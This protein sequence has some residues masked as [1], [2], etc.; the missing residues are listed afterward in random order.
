MSSILRS[1]VLDLVNQRISATDLESW[2]VHQLPNIISNPDSIDSDVVSGI[3]LCL[4]ELHSGIRSQEDF[5]AYMRGI[6]DQY[7][8]LREVVFNA[9][10][11][12]NSTASSNTSRPMLPFSPVNTREAVFKVTLGE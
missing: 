3:E 7:K 12:Q 2:L 10:V 5:V 6:L 11:A 9:S 8:A 1:K 4:A